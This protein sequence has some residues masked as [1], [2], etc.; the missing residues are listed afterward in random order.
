MRVVL[1]EFCLGVVVGEILGVFC[2][3]EVGE[4]LGDLC[5]NE[6]YLLVFNVIVIFLM[7]SRVD[8]FLF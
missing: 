3:E 1:G 6:W 7:D 8:D 4:V 2:C 5:W